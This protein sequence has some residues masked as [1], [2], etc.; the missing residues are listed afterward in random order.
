MPL[1]KIT[2]NSI[3][4]AETFKSFSTGG[5]ERMRI[6]SSGRLLIGTTSAASGYV[7][8]PYGKIY[9]GDDTDVTPNAFWSGQLTIRGNGYA[10]GLS[11][12]ATGMWVGHNSSG[13]ALLFAT[14]ETERMCI[15]TSGKVGIGTSS[16]I[17]RL[18]V[19]SATE[20]VVRITSDLTGVTS[21]DGLFFGL[22]NNGTDATL[23]NYENGYLRFATNNTE[24]MRI[25]SSGRVTMP[26]QPTFWAKGTGTQSWS[27][28]ITPTKVDFTGG[29]QLITGNKS[30]GWSQT[31]SRF[32][33][34]V[35][36]TYEFIFSF[37]TQST[38]T[39]PSLQ[40]Y[41]NGAPTSYGEVAINYYTAY[42][43]ATAIVYV[44]LAASDYV[45]FWI[46]N[47]N[48]STF[49]LD[50]GRTYFGGKLIG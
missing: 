2:S 15:D 49:T 16:P 20:S 31:N 45:E 17:G 29:L 5:V 47:Y 11:L 18:H 42:Q 35:A 7:L 27:G 6:D 25:D 23:W 1:S 22:N 3:S 4:T 44:D 26:Y 10:G 28:A 14:D 12:D 32:T 38:A 46:T 50:R 21:T 39:G 9:A 8:Q 13:R 43:Q 36:G 37:T 34:P 40:F 19:N 48:S 33:A 30:S 24:R 41:K